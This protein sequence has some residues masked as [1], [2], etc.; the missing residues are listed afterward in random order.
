MRSAAFLPQRRF[1][2][3]IGFS[4]ELANFLH[5]KQSLK[6]V[7]IKHQKALCQW[8][9]YRTGSVS[10][11]KSRLS[12]ASNSFSLQAYSKGESD[13]AFVFSKSNA[14]SNN[15]EQLECGSGHSHICQDHDLHLY[16]TWTHRT[17]GE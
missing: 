1:S 17:G 16:V 13:L 10:Q 12:V 11:A 2:Q 15:Q 4:K 5:R 14:L 7:Y 3:L 6:A 8:M 9:N